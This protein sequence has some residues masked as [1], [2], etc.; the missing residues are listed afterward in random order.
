[1]P[2]IPST[3]DA[4]SRIVRVD[5][6]DDVLVVQLVDGRAL[7]V[8]LAWYPRLLDGSAAQRA[9]WVLSGGGFGIHWPE[10]DEDLHVE[11]LLAGAKSPEARV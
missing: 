7:S 10:L 8:P 2:G 4:G 11:G 9:N 1:M 3:P 6:S 5:V